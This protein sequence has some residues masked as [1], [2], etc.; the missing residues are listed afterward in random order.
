MIIFQANDCPA[1]FLASSS[2]VAKRIPLPQCKIFS[3]LLKMRALCAR[4]AKRLD[5]RTTL[6]RK[7]GV[8]ATPAGRPGTRIGGVAEN[9]VSGIR[10][11]VVIVQPARR[12][13]RCLGGRAEAVSPHRRPPGAEPHARR[14]H[15]VGQ[16]L[17]HRHR[18]PP[19][20]WGALRRGSPP[21]RRA[22][23]SASP[24]SAAAPVRPPFSPVS[25]RW[26]PAAS[27]MSSSRMPFAPS[28]T[29]LCSTAAWR[30]LREARWPSC[31]PS[32]LP[33]R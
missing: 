7:S 3:R 16:G 18:D 22:V 25:K 32:R 5:A 15:P 1:P 4:H 21:K 9:E 29:P 33:T 26:P 2:Q 13:G 8:R 6:W 30:R 20:R 12:A 19:G 23:R 24:S 14:P 31:R 28:S 17:P 10:L 27:A 11:G